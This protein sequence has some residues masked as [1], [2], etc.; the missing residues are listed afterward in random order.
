VTVKAGTERFTFTADGTQGCHTVSGIG[1]GS[2]SAYTED[3]EGPDCHAISHAEFYFTCPATAT[4]TATNTP[5]P[6]PTLIPPPTAETPEPTEEPED[7][8]PQPSPPPLLPA[9]GAEGEGWG[10]LRTFFYLLARVLGLW[11]P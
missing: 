1:T 3:E 4:P 5:T 10:R 11:Q 8:T 7:P 2:A 6:K 9:T